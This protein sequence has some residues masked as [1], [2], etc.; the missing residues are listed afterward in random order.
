MTLVVNAPAQSWTLRVSPIFLMNSP[1][2]IQEA[3]AS[4]AAELDATPVVIDGMPAYYSTGESNGEINYS[5]V[6]PKQSIVFIVTMSVMIGEPKTVDLNEYLRSI[7][8]NF[9]EDESDD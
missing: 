1:A 3:S 5:Y 9:Y 6:I 2:L 8:P 4:I 7:L